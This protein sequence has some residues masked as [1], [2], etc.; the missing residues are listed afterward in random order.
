MMNALAEQ[1]RAGR[2]S[3]NP[4]I[5]IVDDDPEIRRALRRCLRGERYELITAE[6]GDQALERLSDGPV[7]LVITDQRM[8][9]MWGT[10][11]LQEIRERLPRT[12]CAILT[13]FRTLSV[14]RDGIDAGASTILFKPWKDGKLRSTVRHLLGGRAAGPPP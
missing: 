8:P 6:S 10:D 12:P 11:L 3:G 13:A 4:V 1:I 9:G 2:R 7:D 14:I 5:L